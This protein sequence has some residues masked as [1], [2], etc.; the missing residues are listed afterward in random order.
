MGRREMMI[1]RYLLLTIKDG[2]SHWPAARTSSAST[3]EKP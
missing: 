3:G 2:K 1:Y